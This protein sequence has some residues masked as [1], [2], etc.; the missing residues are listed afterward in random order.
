MSEEQQAVEP[1]VADVPDVPE[2]QDAPQYDDSA[3]EQARALGWKSPDEWVGE[4]PKG[5][6]EDPERYVEWA[7]KSPAVKALQSKLDRLE[8]I[9]RRSEAA[10]QKQVERERAE[11]QRQ[12]RAIREAKRS[13]LEAGDVE[14][15]RQLDDREE[16][17]RAAS[18]PQEGPQISTVDKAEFETW[19]ARNSDWFGADRDKEKSELAV[20]LFGEAN[21]RGLTTV[22]AQLAYVDHQLQ[23]RAKPTAAPPPAQSKF[24]SGLGL[25]GRVS[26]FSKLPNEAK[27]AFT[28][29]VK[30]G[31]FTDDEAGRKAYA[32]D[33]NAA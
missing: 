30:Q 1:E 28:R 31:L 11:H 23:L 15:A 19:V 27:D 20:Q 21:E 33:Y 25:G 26:S 22:K 5:Y 18:Q 14:A 9:A 7:T 6:I 8:E 10:I 12:L 29:F 16:M 2:T 24:E 4:R 32:E 17:M 3:A 13:A